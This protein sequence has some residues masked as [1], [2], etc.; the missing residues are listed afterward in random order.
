VAA[1]A[2]QHNVNFICIP[3]GRL[4]D[5][6]EFQAQDNVLYDL[7][8][9]ENINGVVSWVSTHSNYIDPGEIESFH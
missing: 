5:T 4:R 7:I 2:R 9:V 6:R 8:S 1:A 3:G